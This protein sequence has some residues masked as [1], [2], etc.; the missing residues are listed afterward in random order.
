MKENEEE[1]L[2]WVKLRVNNPQF[3]KL[4]E[5]LPKSIANENRGACGNDEGRGEREKSEAGEK[6]SRQSTFV[7]TERRFGRRVT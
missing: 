5:S 1:P 2:F 3:Q 6:N 7:K 4:V